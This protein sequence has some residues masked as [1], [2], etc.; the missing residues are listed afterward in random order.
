MKKFSKILVI[1]MLA[2]LITGSTQSISADHTTNTDGIFKTVDEVNFVPTQGSKYQLHLQVMVRDV[3]NQLVSVSE[4][5][6][7]HYIP[8]ALTDFILDNKLNGKEIITMGNIEYEKFQI[9]DRPD[10][11]QR[12]TGLYPI[13]SET[14]MDLNIQTE[15]TSHDWITSWKVHYCA[16]F[17]EIGHKFT[18]I[19]LF[20]TLTPSVSIENGDTVINQWTILRSLN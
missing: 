14:P 10:F 5:K 2:T 13:L 8:H 11:K 4:S 20:Q 19:P 16:D 18:C 3:N 7:G 17:T 15:R 12:A 6:S 9:I 1:A